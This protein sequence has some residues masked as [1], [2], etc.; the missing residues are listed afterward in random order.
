M[1]DTINIDMK[2]A[3]QWK[4]SSLLRAMIVGGCLGIAAPVFAQT[5][6]EHMKDMENK[7]EAMQNDLTQMTSGMVTR[8]SSGEGLPI[9]GFMDVGFASNSKGTSANPMG[10]Y[11]GALS[12]YLA[13]HFGDKVKA[14]VEPNFEVTRDGA[15]STDL[16]RLQIGYTFSDNATAWAGRFHTPYG[17]W[18]TAFHHGAQI[19]TSVLRPRFLDFEDKGG[20]LPAH[21]I[22]LWG[23]GK[24]KVG[25][26]KLT[27]DVFAGNGPKIVKSI[28]DINQAGDNNHQ[29]MVGFNLGYEFS[30]SLDGLRLAVHSLRGD[31]DDDAVPSNKTQ[32]NIVG[33]SAV[34]LSDTWEVMSEYYRFND[35]DKSGGT[36]THKSWAD[37]LQIGKSFNN[38]TPYV[39][40]ER[41]V[42]DQLDNYFSMQDSGQSYARQALG[43]RYNLNPKAALKFELLNS[44][45]KAESGRTALGYRSVFVQYAIGF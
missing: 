34:Y 18:N 22:G 25:D 8:S 32:L 35:K 21:M 12:F 43:L 19:Q 36:G 4:G 6:A 45:F 13:P 7:L 3:K 37:Y 2:Q 38:L 28:L 40:V 26:S 17:Y 27:Y 30:G 33:G 42:L 5:D 29:A 16:E 10:F 39:R 31:V 11:V 44:S 41:T 23:E 9:H 20:I 15:I 1:V 24:F 14:L